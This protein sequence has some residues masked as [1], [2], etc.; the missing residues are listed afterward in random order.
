MEFDITVMPNEIRQESPKVI[1]SEGY[2]PYVG[3]YIGSYSYMVD[4][5]IQNRFE[6]QT[7]NGYLYYKKKS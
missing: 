7:K 4:M 3:A 5:H 1:V 2:Q 6:D